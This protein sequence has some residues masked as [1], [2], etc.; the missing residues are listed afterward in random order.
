MAFLDIFKKKTSCD[1]AEEEL[2]G[3]FVETSIDG[4]ESITTNQHNDFN[5]FYDR[6]GF[7]HLITTEKDFTITV[8]NG[9]YTINVK[10]QEA[11]ASTKPLTPYIAK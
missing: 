7:L 6:K 4:V 1:C 3:T 9:A 11:T 2:N 5:L 10:N 8:A